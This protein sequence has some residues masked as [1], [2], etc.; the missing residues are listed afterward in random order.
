MHVKYGTVTL[1]HMPIVGLFFTRAMLFNWKRFCAREASC[2]EMR[3]REW[4]DTGRGKWS[5]GSC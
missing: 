4:V 2:M 1:Y 5:L 3:D